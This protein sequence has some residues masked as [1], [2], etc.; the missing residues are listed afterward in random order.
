[1]PTGGVTGVPTGGVTNKKSQ[2][3]TTFVGVSCGA[4]LKGTFTFT[5][6]PEE[7]ILVIFASNI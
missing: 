3:A 1:M 4:L 6:T 5:E 2:G 7:F